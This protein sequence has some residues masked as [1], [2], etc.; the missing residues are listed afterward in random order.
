MKKQAGFRQ[1]FNAVLLSRENL[2]EEQKELYK[3]IIINEPN[4]EHIY[5]MTGNSA[6]VVSKIDEMI[7]NYKQAIPIAEQVIA[8]LKRWNEQNPN[9]RLDYSPTA[10]FNKVLERI[11]RGEKQIN[12]LLLAKELLNESG[13]ALSSYCY[14]NVLHIT[15]AQHRY[16]VAAFIDLE[17]P[18]HVKSKQTT[19][20]M[21]RLHKHEKRQQKKRPP[22]QCK[23]KSE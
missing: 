15:T 14:R 2:S 21:R 3:K 4:L 20:D 1:L 9:K 22:L 16:L 19:T 8:K 12:S 10:V 6:T 7:P 18:P 5:N 23:D 13:I 11:K 17:E